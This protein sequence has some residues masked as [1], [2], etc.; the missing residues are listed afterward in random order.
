MIWTDNIK[1]LKKYVSSIDNLTSVPDAYSIIIAPV[2]GHRDS[3]H[4]EPDLVGIVQ[5][6][7]K[8][9]HKISAHDIVSFTLI[10]YFLEKS[11]IYN[12]VTGKKCLKCS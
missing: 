5:L 12:C 2:F 7:N 1:D 4:E 8:A 10:C 3:A 9:D 11:T 6:I